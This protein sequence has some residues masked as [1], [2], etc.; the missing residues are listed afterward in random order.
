MPRRAPDDTPPD[1]PDD[2]LEPAYGYERLSRDRESKKK[3]RVE[4]QRADIDEHGPLL[5]YN[6]VQHFEDN[7]VSASKY[8]IDRPGFDTLCE[9][10]KTSGVRNVLVTEVTRISRQDESGGA[11]MGIMTRAGGKVIKVPEGITYDF[12][13]PHGRDQF[14][15]ALHDAIRESE[16]ISDRVLKSQ[17]R[18]REKKRW[19]GGP[20]PYGWRKE[21]YPELVD[22]HYETRIIWVVDEAEAEHIREMC[23]GILRGESVAMIAQRLNQSGVRPRRSK[24]WQDSSIRAIV[25]NPRIC[26]LYGRQVDGVWQVPDVQPEEQQFPPIVDFATWDAVQVS[27]AGRRLKRERITA[28]DA[29]TETAG[30]FRCAACQQTLFRHSANH[31]DRTS[32]IR[33]PSPGRSR[34]CPADNK[35]SV[36]YEETWDYVADLIDLFILT[37][38]LRRRTTEVRDFDA[39]LSRVE[40][41][42]AE[43]NSALDAGDIT[44]RL[45]GVRE[46]ALLEKEREIKLARERVRAGNRRVINL[47][48]AATWRNLPLPE[49]RE[50]IFGVFDHIDISPG[51]QGSSPWDYKRFTPFFTEEMSPA[52]NDLLVEKSA[53]W[54]EVAQW[55]KAGAPKD[56]TALVSGRLEGLLSAW[57]ATRLESADPQLIDNTFALRGYL[58]GRGMMED[59]RK[60][61]RDITAGFMSSEEFG[62]RWS[63]M[64]GEDQHL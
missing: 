62:E 30:L 13:T 29:V 48:V 19:T 38:P 53:A 7:S 52:L 40:R 26:G 31:A 21:K 49:M 50:I 8:D 39:E 46:K 15:M 42:L 24:Y 2:H 59:P 25:Q 16:K 28:H 12:S 64:Y 1:D 10:L 23:T 35:L 6:L 34:P 56:S 43:L 57:A 27:L 33:H 60:P 54:D 61:L 20:A 4:E 45:A 22:G 36:S 51:I 47:G 41:D 14:R 17:A 9:A 44:L 58:R 18:L 37:A 63:E 3:R 55:L 32:F 5:G 11:F